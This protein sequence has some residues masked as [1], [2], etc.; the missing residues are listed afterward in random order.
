MHKRLFLYATLAF[1]LGLV[2][3]P[4]IDGTFDGIATWG[5][6]IASD[7]DGSW[8]SVDLDDLY[9]TFD[10]TYV[11]LGAS[12]T[13][14]AD[15]Q[16]WGFVLNTSSGGGS[17][18][19]WG[20]P[21]TYGHSDLPD[22]VV[23]GHFGQGAGSYAELRAWNGSSWTLVIGG[24]TSFS[25]DEGN[26]IVEV[27]V[28][29]STLGSPL[30]LDVQFYVTGNNAGE[31]GTFDAIPDDENASSWNVSSSPTTLDNYA[32]SI[33]I[34]PTAQTAGNWTNSATWYRSVTPGTSSEVNIAANVTL[35]TD[36]TISC[37]TISQEHSPLRMDLLAPSP[38]LRAMLEPKE[39][40]P[41]LVPGPMEAEAARSYSAEAQVL[42]MPY[43]KPQVHW[44]CRM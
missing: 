31:H 4:T 23:K 17:S 8:A 9:V 27:Q 3:Q 21:I 28:E 22:H 33:P 36:A 26:A 30:E 19:V 24:I 2:A 41:T 37:L 43:T 38:L 32:A 15:W 6:S 14:V 25:S 12:F 35:D 29:R 34:V 42:E 18:E 7:G 44:A 11:Y 10:D 16:S 13:T 40:Y 5:S 39:L 1:S 20:Y